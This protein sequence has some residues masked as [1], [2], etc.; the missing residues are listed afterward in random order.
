ML[1]DRDRRRELAAVVDA[2]HHVL[3]ARGHRAVGVDEV[4]QLARRELRE[5]RVLAAVADL[6]PA[7]V[8]HPQRRSA[9][10]ALGKARD[11][12]GEQAEAAA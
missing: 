9:R 12:P 7:D 1:R 8:R 10:I 5:H 11:A 4:V 6:V 2:A 3:L